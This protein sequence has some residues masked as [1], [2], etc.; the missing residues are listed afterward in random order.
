MLLHW[1]CQ[2][3]K[4]KIKR[5][6]FRE[7][8]II[9]NSNIHVLDIDIKHPTYINEPLIRQNDSVV[10]TINI[11]DDNAPY[12]LS[13]VATITLATKRSDRIIIISPGEKTDINQ[14]TFKLPRSAVSL[15]GKSNAT[16][17]MYGA[18]NRVS[19]LSFTFKVEKD[20]A[21]DD[22]T[23][24][25]GEKTLIEVVLGDGPVILANAEQATIYANEQGDYAKD[26][27]DKLVI[28]NQT[29]DENESERIDN[30]INRES[31]EAT[32]VT[33]EDA[34][35]AAEVAR[36]TAEQERQTN[37]SAAIQNAESATSDAVSATDAIN[38]VLPNVIN[39][40][41]V[42]PYDATIQYEK[43]NIVRHEKNSY[44]AL[45]STLG[46]EPTGTTDSLFW[47][48]IAVGGVDGTG[49]GTVTAV[50]GV[51]PDDTGN[52][53]IEIP[54]PDVSELVTKD[55]LN[56]RGVNVK[57]YGAIGDGLADDTVAL[58][59]ALTS[60]DALYFPSGVYRI[61]QSIAWDYTRD[62]TWRGID[63]TILLD[64]ETHFERAVFLKGSGVEFKIDGINFN[65]NKMC[66]K[67][68]EFDNETTD[69]AENSLSSIHLKDVNVQ[70][71]KRSNEF[72]G[73]SGIYTRGAYTELNLLN[74][75][76]KDCEL[77][78][79]Q[80]T[81]GIVGIGGLIV[82]HYGEN[83]YTLQTT[84]R[85]CKIEKI[86]SSDLDYQY[87]QDG[88]IVFAPHIDS[89]GEYVQGRLIVD[90]CEFINCYGRSIKSQ[91]FSNTV[92]DSFFKRAEGL[93]SKIGNAEIDFQLSGGIAEGLT[94]DYSNGFHPNY[95]VTLGTDA[96]YGVPSSS[97]SDCYVYL[98][99]ST[100]LESFA[101]LYHRNAGV[102]GRVNISGISIYGKV[103]HP[104]EARVN[105]DKHYLVISD[106]L[107]TEIVPG[108]TS[109]K[110]LVYVSS[111]G[112]LLPAIQRV[113]IHSCRHTG[114]D[115]PSLVRD[116][117]PGNVARA[118]VDSWNNQGFSNDK[119]ATPNATGLRKSQL[120][121]VG[122]IGSDLSSETPVSGFFEIKTV[123]IDPDETK[124][125]PVANISS[126]LL[127]INSNFNHNSFAIVS[128]NYRNNTVITKG[129][130]FEVA[131]NVEPE[132]GTF[133]MWSSGENE[134][135]IKNTNAS[136]RVFSIFEMC[137]Y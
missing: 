130:E 30:E 101:A 76:I 3:K 4:R 48:V 135:S 91:T 32:R 5:L 123:L 24:S 66:N 82:S 106:M 80:G 124:V 23:P 137:P 58:Q 133:R 14:V 73:G 86:Y 121:R 110:A 56:E 125:I 6:K 116:S 41:Y 115:T 53:E 25:D 99:D 44:I 67:V 18:D 68:L 96:G 13:N 7:E 28:L 77:P 33:N 65:G 55:E 54:D 29:V 36:D 112:T 92:R 98:D 122:R 136:A 109:E 20:P 49:T 88:I 1:L 42:A 100:I 57:K 15:V 105:G 90:N 19:T 84:L 127:F 120:A 47:G 12:D 75:T 17:Q 95:C 111:N 16:V 81:L 35:I 64:A 40:E 37:T 93:N 132:E 118:I 87:D 85:D 78:A 97:I 8:V 52:V 10:F 72:N 46:N 126:T 119:K 69:M 62:V 131:N 107:T 89:L 61:T 21:G 71:A 43:N 26:E 102:L 2:Y 39:L 103:R 134:I 27:A 34:R 113:T 22:W 51:E 60:E 31:A 117:I 38:L 74:V 11:T 128:S 63:A 59:A 79:E 70:G 104:I 83:S 9:L 50:N 129:S 45:Q 108:R 114:D 94:F